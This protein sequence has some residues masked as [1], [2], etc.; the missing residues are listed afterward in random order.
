MAE[1]KGDAWFVP[2][3]AA[4]GTEVAPRF[5]QAYQ[6][7]SEWKRGARKLEL[8]DDEVRDLVAVRIVHEKTG[9]PVDEAMALRAQ[10]KDLARMLA[11]ETARP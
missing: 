6:A 3:H 1:I 9:V 8:T 10:G 5:R 7:Q 2:G 4:S 11:E